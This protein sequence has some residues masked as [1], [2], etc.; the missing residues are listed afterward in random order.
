MTEYRILKNKYYDKNLPAD[1]DGLVKLDLSV[2]CFRNPEYGD[3]WGIWEYKQNGTLTCDI[4]EVDLDRM[5]SSAAVLDWIIQVSH[6]SWVT[7]DDLA[8]L[9][10]AIDDILGLQQNYCGFGKEIKK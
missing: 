9:I 10:Y 3:T 6:K 7:E 5:E 1:K 2:K 8:D 4:Y